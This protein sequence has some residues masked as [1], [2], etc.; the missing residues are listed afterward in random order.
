METIDILGFSA[1]V[2]TTLAFIPQVLKTWKSR[3]TNDLS[4][5]WLLSFGIGVGMW[6]VYGFLLNSPPIIAAN[7]ATLVLIGVLLAVKIRN[8]IK[9]PP[10]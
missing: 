5:L 7:G 4:L 3:S 9:N 1:G 10:S 8:G 6:L 2:I